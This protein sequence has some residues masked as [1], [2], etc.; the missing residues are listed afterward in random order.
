MN[1]RGI[2]SSLLNGDGAALAV[3]FPARVPRGLPLSTFLHKR[4]VLKSPY[5]GSLHELDIVF[6]SRRDWRRLDYSRDPDFRV[7][8]VGPFVIAFRLLMT[9]GGGA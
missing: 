7:T 3:P 2:P 1:Y 6:S 5:D 9:K 4:H 8:D